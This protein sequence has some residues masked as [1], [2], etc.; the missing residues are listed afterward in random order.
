MRTIIVG[1]VGISA[2]LGTYIVS[3]PDD[4]A[5]SGSSTPQNAGVHGRADMAKDAAKQLAA[6]QPS[7]GA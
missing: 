4:N 2:I 6:D 3:L 1:T 7:T 5:V